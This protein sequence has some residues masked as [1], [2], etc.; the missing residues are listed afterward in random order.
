[1][2]AGA[3]WAGKVSTRE[4]T[5]THTGTMD[6]S[7][8]PGDGVARGIR[9]GDWCVVRMIRLILGAAGHGP[10]E[11]AEHGG[12]DGIEGV[13][14][15][16]SGESVGSEEGGLDEAGVVTFGDGLPL[17]PRAAGDLHLRAEAEE[18]GSFDALD[19][20]EIQ[21]LAGEELV[22]VATATSEAGSAQEAIE[23]AAQPPDAVPDEPAVV[24]AEA[25]DHVVDAVG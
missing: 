14:V 20:P 8:G 10:D 15:E 2:V 12:V 1:M 24:A 21:G 5:R 19:A 25:R 17:E 9:S 4:H 23:E 18:S 6:H 16:E 7:P 3:G 13:P 11:A 22:G